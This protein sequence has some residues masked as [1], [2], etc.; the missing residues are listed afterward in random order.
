MRS[1]AS[2]AAAL[3]LAGTV[4]SSAAWAQAVVTPRQEQ[5][6]LPAGPYLLSCAHPHRVNGRLVALCDDQASAMHGQD[7][8]RMAQLSDPRQCGGPIENVNGRLTCGT[9]PMVGSSAPP[10]YIGSS[11]GT[12]GPGYGN[13]GVSA[14][15]P[16]RPPYET[17]AGGYPNGRPVPAT[18]PRM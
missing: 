2:V 18:S 5:A 1:I 14:D 11:F 8:W 10:Q 6:R 17:G 4:L 13:S 12:S 9:V 3:L 15:N 7:S 16:Y